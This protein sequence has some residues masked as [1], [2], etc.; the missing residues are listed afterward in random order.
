MIDLE[1]IYTQKEFATKKQCLNW[2]ID[3]LERK[4]IVSPA[5]RKE[6]FE[7][8]VIGETALAT[9]VAIPHASPQNVLQT[10]IT[11]VTLERPIVWDQ[12]KVQYILLMCI[13]KTDRKLVRGLITDIHKIVQSEKKL[14]HFFAEKTATEIYETIIRR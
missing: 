14:T 2:L 1:F 13:A 10:K 12:R 7:R 11:I 8:E 6:V 4:N 3:Q 5:F 9:G